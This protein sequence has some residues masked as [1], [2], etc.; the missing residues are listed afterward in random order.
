MKPSWAVT[1]LTPRDG[2]DHNLS[3]NNGAEGPT[4]DPAIRHRRLADQRALLATLLLSRGAPMLAMGSEL[5]HSQGG[6]NNAYAQD[7]AVGWLDWAG[8]DHA[9]IAFTGRLVR[10]RADCPALR[11]DRFLTGEPGAHGFPDV[12]WLRPDGQP[13]TPADWDDPAG[14]TLICVLTAGEDPASLSRAVVIAHRGGEAMARLPEARDGHA[15]RLAIDTADDARDGVVSDDLGLKARSMVLLIE[16]AAPGRKSGVADSDLAD[17]SSRAGL[18]PEWWTI[19]GERQVASPQTQRALLAAMG[20]QADTQADLSDALW[21]LGA[22]ERRALPWTLTL[23]EGSPADLRVDAPDGW[24]LLEMESGETTPLRL[25]GGR[26]NLPPLPLGR[27]RLRLND[28]HCHLIAAPDLAYEPQPPRRRLGV[29]AQLY[30]VRGTRDAGMGDL[31]TLAELARGAGEQGLSLVG[32]NPLH[33]LFPTDRSRV[34]PY[35]PSD[36]RFLDPIYIATPGLAAAR[37]D[38]AALVDYEGVWAAKSALLERAFK[39]FEAQGGDPAFDA[40]LAEGGETLA[41]FCLFQA[42]AERHPDTPWRLW[43]KGLDDAAGPAAASFAQA[44]AERLRYHAWLQW[45]ADRQLGE[46]RAAGVEFLR[47][48]A[49]GPAPDGAE[50]WAGRGLFAAGVSL[51]APPDG[52][53]PQGQVW[54]MPPPLPGAWTE[55]GFEAFG[56]LLRN[57]MRHAGALRIDHALGLARMFWIPE[58]ADGAEGTYV[59]YPMQDLLAVIALESVRAQCLVVGEDL[60]TAPEALRPAMQAR[61]IYSYKVLPFERDGPAYRPPEAYPP[62]ALAC[63]ATHD[64]PTLAGWWTGAD[65][66]ERAALGLLDGQA[67]VEAKQDRA[68][69]KGV[70]LQ[71]LADAGLAPDQAR[72]DELTDDLAAAIHAYVAASPSLLVVAQAEDLAG[73]PVSINMPGTHLERANWRRRLSLPLPQLWSTPRAKAILSALESAGR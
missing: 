44:Q 32:L 31:E 20:L 72:P 43:P 28:L 65:I 2:T 56:R 22:P 50:V 66:E 25:R 19:A 27:H 10:A 16:D 12:A 47:D 52:F 33:V 45:R 1:K 11:Q 58:G 24:A 7:N 15:W 13:M 55:D 35:Y 51:G 40:F 54:G 49:I 63:V 34:S 67:L 46:A 5:G 17:L 26:C 6:N 18:A 8:A 71:A 37:P 70:L 48:L 3:W 53:S 61:R 36:R 69:D 29:S 59:R 4:D 21:R 41:A 60:G 30:A 39:G 9:L 57:N 14:A 62:R 73:E 38:P 42:I 68:R 64:L 23:A